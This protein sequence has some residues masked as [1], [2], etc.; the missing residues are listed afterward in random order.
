MK[1]INNIFL[2]KKILVYGLGKSGISTYKFL[3]KSSEVY[4][5]D[6][7]HRINLKFNQKIISL[8][9]IKKIN[10]DRIII[11]P[12]IDI[13]NCKLSKFLNNNLIKIHTDL[14]V[15]FSFYDNKSITI[16]GTNGK[17]TT[18]KILH[19][20]LTDQKRDSRLIGNIGNPVLAEK[21]ITNKTIFVIEASSY[22]LDYSRIF[23]SKYALILNITSDHIER[24]KSLNNYVDAKFKL[25][26]SQNRGSFAYI[27]KDDEL[28]TKK[29]KK[30]KY[31]AKI[32]KVQTSN[33]N[34]KFDKIYNKYFISDGNKEN[35]L[36]IFEIA[37]K[38]KLNKKKLI[39]SINRFKGLDYRQ[40]IIFDKKNLTIINDSK[41]TSFASS[42]SVLK[43]LNGAYWILG[44]IPKKGD[45][46]KLSKAKCKNL[47]AFIF[48]SHSKKFLKILKNKLKV[49]SFKNLEETL[50]VI[51]SEITIQKSEKNI[52]F[53]SPAG[54]SFDSF[55][56]FEDRGNYFNQ[57]VKKYINAK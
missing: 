28:I 38:L 29:I 20:I 31:K 26:K 23:R 54:A 21:N 44:G 36:F 19:D 14:D 43:N 47:K 22:Q 1:K 45:K 40:Q 10:F 34:K 50:K 4:L 52:I 15:L 42:E 5:F 56:N 25:L 51:F 24:H 7:N 18:A 35:L 37:S 17:S 11:S 57:L 8:K 53:F 3:K 13:S 49:K 39:K 48:G 32:Y 33:L 55:K 9:Q 12:G 27:K 2:G 30:N 41:S 46:F 16:T 6:D